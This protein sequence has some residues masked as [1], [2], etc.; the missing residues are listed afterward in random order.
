MPLTRGRAQ[1]G[2]GSAGLP[3][4]MPV[5]DALWGETQSWR[6]T[7]AWADTRAELLGGTKPVA[8]RPPHNPTT[9]IST[10]ADPDR[11]R[12]QTWRVAAEPM[13]NA[14]L[15]AAENNPPLPMVDPGCEQSASGVIASG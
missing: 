4:G 7:W 6:A 14:G 1:Q 2:V 5:A 15:P 10:S 13:R 8:P 3:A 12:T 9:T 11:S